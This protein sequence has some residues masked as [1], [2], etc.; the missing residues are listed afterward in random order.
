[1]LTLT[2]VTKE[3]KVSRTTLWRIRKRTYIPVT[4]IGSRPRFKKQDIDKLIKSKTI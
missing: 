1:M 2:D 3:V 4:Y